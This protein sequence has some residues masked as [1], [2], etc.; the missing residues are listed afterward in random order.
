MAHAIGAMAKQ[1]DIAIGERDALSREMLT[2][3][4]FQRLLDWLREPKGRPARGVG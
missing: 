4:V 3:T 1:R 2:A